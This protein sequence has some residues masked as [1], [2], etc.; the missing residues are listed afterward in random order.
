MAAVKAAVGVRNE[1][2][3]GTHTAE[4]A[5]GALYVL[6]VMVRPKKRRRRR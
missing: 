6:G 3:V 2:Y 1:L 5:F 4:V